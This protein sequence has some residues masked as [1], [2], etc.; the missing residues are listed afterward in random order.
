MC[1]PSLSTIM[2]QC[3]DKTCC[4]GTTLHFTNHIWICNWKLAFNR[5][6]VNVHRE[7][8][9]RVFTFFISNASCS[10]TLG[11]LV[12]LNS[13]PD[14]A[15]TSQYISIYTSTVVAMGFNIRVCLQMRCSINHVHQILVSSPT[16]YAVSVWHWL[17]ITY[18]QRY[19]D[20]HDTVIDP[21]CTLCFAS[22]GRGRDLRPAAPARPA[23]LWLGLLAAGARGGGGDR[24][25]PTH[26]GFI[27]YLLFFI[28]FA[29]I[30]DGWIPRY[31]PK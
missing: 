31:S 18:L 11:T 8:G 29:S 28:F 21:E 24:V 13:I 19:H 30:S 26:R 1:K 27:R 4:H 16:M 15:T 12:T 20:G 14:G 17:H 9:A 25:R 10:I 7:E 3:V 5:C 22:S 23:G 2:W 6:V